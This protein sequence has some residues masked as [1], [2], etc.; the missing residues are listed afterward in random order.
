MMLMVDLFVVACIQLSDSARAKSI[1]CPINY[2]R[3]G[4][5][6]GSDVKVY[7]NEAAISALLQFGRVCK[8]SVIQ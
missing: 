2:L 3:R 5:K 6:T 7:L 4:L 8:R 1:F